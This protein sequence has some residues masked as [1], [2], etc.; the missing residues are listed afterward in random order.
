MI[1]CLIKF[2]QYEN[3]FISFEQIINEMIIVG[4]GQALF[5]FFSTIHMKELIY[6]NVPFLG[7]KIHHNVVKNKSCLHT[8]T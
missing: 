8:N 6:T 4:H 3:A 2:L 5:R 1:A 7:H